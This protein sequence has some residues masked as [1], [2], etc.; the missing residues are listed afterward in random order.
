MRTN[1]IFI[2]VFAALFILYI[3]VQLN[4]PK[5][6]DWTVSL[7]AT[8]KN[9]FG[10]F[11]LHEQL[12]QLFPSAAIQSHRVPIYNVLHDQYEEKSAYILLTASF[13][14]GNADLSEMLDYV[15]A[16]NTVLLSAVDADKKLLDTLGLS[17][18]PFAGFIE[19]DSTTI[20]FVNPALHSTR[21]YGF[22]RQTID[23]YFNKITKQDSVIVLGTR[24]DTLPNFVKV[25]YGDGF[26]LVHAAPLCF[27]NYF[28]LYHNNQEYTAKA[29]SYIPSTVKTLHW[30]EYYKLGR[31]GASTPLRFFLNNTFLRWALWLSVIAALLYVLFQ[32]KRKQ[33]IIPVIEPVKNTTL[34]FVQTVSS[35]YFGQKDNNSIAHKK[36]LF[37]QEYV[38]QRYY[39][40]STAMDANFVQQL[41][42]KSGVSKELIETILKNLERATAQPK[43]TDA[44]L[45]ELTGSIDEFYQLSKKIV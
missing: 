40:G 45:I 21:D 38:R 35:V 37:W 24:S 10:T 5:E 3:V 2:I 11:V 28:M 25:L 27:S 23:G 39:L 44:L 26:F 14:P 29:L 15:S 22:K 36:I 41:A 30:D 13:T 32:A 33:R 12:K 1:K 16:G 43:V 18:Q 19:H 17:F 34:E 9:P 8:D 31:E 6:F 7:S 42:R 4:K 20:N